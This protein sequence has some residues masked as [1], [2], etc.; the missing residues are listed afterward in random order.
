MPIRLNLCL[1]SVLL[2]STCA[3]PRA[4]TPTP[5]EVIEVPCTFETTL[6]PGVPGSPGHPLPSTLHPE[7]AS[8]L[9]MLMRAMEKD[10][11]LVRDALRKGERPPRLSPRHRRIRCSWPTDPADRTATFDALAQTYLAQVEA[12]DAQPTPTR[13]AFEHVLD[14]CA[15]CHQNSCPGAIA[16]IDALRREG[17]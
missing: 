16:A 10:L 6:V 14:G 7:G 3:S 15:A 8:E 1:S 11:G 13:A 9:A 5:P 12:L 4:A 17:P 2:L